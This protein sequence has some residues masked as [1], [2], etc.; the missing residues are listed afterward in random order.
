MQ[1]IKIICDTD[2]GS[3]AP[4]PAQFVERIAARAVVF[5]AHNN[6]ALLHATN[7]GYHKLPGGGVEAGESVEEVLAREM[8]EEMI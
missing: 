3:N 2:V 1:V 8:A 5:D 7:K 6:V 4:A